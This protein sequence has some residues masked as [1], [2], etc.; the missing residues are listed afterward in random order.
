MYLVLI[1]PFYSQLEKTEAQREK[2]TCQD[3]SLCPMDLKAHL[4]P[5]PTATCTERSAVS[6]LPSPTCQLWGSACLNAPLLFSCPSHLLAR[7]LRFGFG[8]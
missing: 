6:P 2:V 1:P 5:R 3:S 8:D 4:N 7:V